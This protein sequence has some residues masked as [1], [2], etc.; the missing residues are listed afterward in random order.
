MQLIFKNTL[1]ALYFLHIELKIAHRDIKPENI[2]F[3]KN[4]FKLCDL[5]IHFLIIFNKYPKNFKFIGVAKN[6]E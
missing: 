6:I 2:L 5:G 3:I 4:Q 1:D